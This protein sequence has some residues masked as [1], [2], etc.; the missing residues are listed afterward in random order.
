MDQ[1]RAQKIK[2]GQL[3][4]VIRQKTAMYTGERSLSALAHFLLG[5]GFALQVCE[6]QLPDYLPLDFHEW[7]AYRLHF[8]ESTSGYKDMI[9]K[10]IPDESAAFDRFFELLDE[11][12]IRQARVVA[13]VHGHPRE[14]TTATFHDG[15]ESKKVGVLPEIL[16]LVAYTDDP[17]F[18]V[19]CDDAGTEFPSK[20]RFFATI[21]SFGQRFGVQKGNVSVLDAKTFNRWLTE[22]ERFEFSPKPTSHDKM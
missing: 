6:I 5:Y 7:V 3:L 16:T 4:D 10:R 8:F 15:V 12:R 1:L 21:K 13:T 18:F 11:H 19:S 14:Y 2:S 17:G 22:E 9:L 20:G